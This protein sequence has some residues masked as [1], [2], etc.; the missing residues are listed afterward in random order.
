MNPVNKKLSNGNLNRLKH[1]TP[2]M[3]ID[4][5]DVRQKYSNMRTHLPDFKISYAVKCNPEEQILQ[6]LKK[7]GSSFEIASLGELERLIKIGVDPSTVINSNPVK[8]VEQIEAAYKLGVRHFAF[9]SPEE[10]VKIAQ[11]APD[12]RV[13]LR[14]SVSNH[15]SLINLANKFGANKSHAVHLLSLAEDI[16]LE[17]WG[18][19][20]H[21]GSQS[22][23]TQ[24]WDQAFDDVIDVMDDLEK[25]GIKI[26]CLNIGGGFPIQYTEKIPS[27]KEIGQKISKNLEKLPY[28]VQLWC[29]PG[30]YIVGEGG[31]IATTIIGK[32]TRY[33]KPW[34]FVDAG[35]FQAFVEMFESDS[36]QYPIFTSIDKK[37]GAT[38]Q[39]LYTVTGPSCD[40]YDTISRDVSLPTNLQVGDKVYFASTGAY[41][42]VYGSPFND[43]P[44]PK[45]FFEK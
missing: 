29:E 12:A 18:L 33:N 16:G 26:S 44:V 32:T 17:A 8:P 21:V 10:L 22:E 42:H 6:T 7:E 13:Y 34:I 39:S 43:F 9:D 23:S 27:L 3:V 15:G 41:T 11:V 40:S 25:Q 38:P 36:L 4:L 35:R 28:K 14:L 45:V 20:F 37:S 24:L 5:D 1:K 30:R 31:V 2:F 19:A